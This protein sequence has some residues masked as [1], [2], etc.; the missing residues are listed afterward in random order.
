[1]L[2]AFVFTLIGLASAASATEVKSVRVRAADD[3]TRATIDLSD[4]PDYRVFTLANPDR[5]VVDIRQGRL[6]GNID[7]DG[8][9]VVRKV[10]SGQPESDR[11]RIVFDLAGPVRPKS[12]MLDSTG[13]ARHRLVVDMLPAGAAAAAVATVAAPAP[14]QPAAPVGER[15]VIVAIDAG[16]GGQDPGAI[17]AKGTHEKAITLK[18]AQLLAER[19]NAEPGMR[20]VLIRDDD[21]F[22]QLH[23]R[24]Q[25]ARTEKADLFVSI[26]ADAA[27][28]RS[29]K[30]SSVYML[31]TRGASNE[32]ARYLAERENRADLVGGV[33]LNDKDK[34]LAAVL[35][36]LSQGATLEASAVAAEHVLASLTRM[37]KAHKR[38]VERANFVVLRSPD[39]PSLLVETGFIS[40]PEEE[41]KLN[42]PRHRAR[43]AEAVML[44]IRD[45]FHSAPPPGTWIAANV[46]TRA[47]VVARG[48]TLSEI[49][50]RHGVSVAKIRKENS[51]RSDMVRAGAVLK[52]PTAS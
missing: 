19:I 34:M 47:H 26:H 30:G 29:A 37:G 41:K 24:F 15:E 48:E 45:Y 27:L 38:Q 49:A 8:D 20:A 11:L 52:I 5:L 21:T 1:M 18:V 43:L 13:R 31:S 7:G 4:S 28:N 46:K 32:A 40:N 42:D 22:V 36:D 3:H 33:S 35:L 51:L 6:R 9:G 10:R 50:S 14:P 39:V 23:E 16:H 44:G 25:K 17:G 2:R 12:F